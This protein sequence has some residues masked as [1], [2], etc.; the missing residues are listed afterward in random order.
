MGFEP[1]VSR[2]TP[3]FK[4]GAFVRSAIPPRT[5]L[6]MRASRYRA[7][8]SGYEQHPIFQLASDVVDELAQHD[9]T[10]ASR[11][12]SPA[13]VPALP[14]YDPSWYE[15]SYA[16]AQG[17]FDAMSAL[18]ADDDV[19]RRARQVVLDDMTTTIARSR[20]HESERTLSQIASPVADIRQIF[21]LMPVASAEEQEFFLERLA[22]VPRALRGVQ[23]TWQATKE[24]GELPALR[25]I[26]GVADQAQ[27]YAAGDFEALVQRVIPT[28]Q[29][30][31]KFASA[32]KA[33]QAAYSQLAEWMR[34]ELAPAANPV[35][36]CGQERYETLVRSFTGSTWGWQ[37]LYEWGWEDLRGI[38]ADMRR[39]GE[40]ILPGAQNPR[41]VADFLDRDPSRRIEGTDALLAALRRITDGAIEMLDGVHFDIDPRIRFCDVRLAPPGGASAAYYI[42]PS[43][44][45]S[46]PGTTWFPT[47]GETSF[48]LWQHTSTWYHEGLPGHHLE[49]GTAVIN[50]GKLTRYHRLAGWTPGYGEGWA[51]YAERLMHEIGA[52]ADPADELGYL[53]NQALRAARVVVDIGLHLDLPVPSGV[54]GPDVTKWTP[55]RAVEILRDWALQPQITA[56]SEV[57]RY[58]G[59]PGQAIS[60]KVGEREWMRARERAKARMAEKFSLKA[61]HAYG[62]ELGPLGLATFAA[63]ME[64]FG[65]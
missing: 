33:A 9:S 24:R 37:E 56:I 49:S 21:E 36:G 63:E 7:C 16:M 3:V 43:E 19:T 53:A 2:P 18:S 55:E 6:V 35:E 57:E 10:F 52:L 59:W 44:D 46:R 62:L 26:T 4:T 14:A 13:A 25:H 54:F 23:E 32:A 8:M 1:T 40:Q 64:K 48:S 60:Y 51:L 65:Q 50:A 61:F 41:E 34:Q 27:E 38:V 58:L 20:T 15:E 12:G 31:E 5:T 29:Q 28:S 42:S 30:S 47:M 11:I 22:S 39:V 17:A 45:L